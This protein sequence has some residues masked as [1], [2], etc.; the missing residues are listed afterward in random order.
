[1]T[2][3]VCFLSLFVPDLDAARVTYGSVFG[4]TAEA[5]SPPVPERHPFSPKPP[6]VFDLGGVKLALFE[7]DGRV[8]HAGDVGIGVVG[9]AT[10]LLARAVR[11]RGQTLLPPTPIGEQKLAVFVLPDRHFFEVIDAPGV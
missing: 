1:M 6:A 10:G 2:P 9:D 3:Q 8:T 7:V 5:A 4:V 11:A